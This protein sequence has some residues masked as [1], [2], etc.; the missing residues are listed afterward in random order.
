VPDYYSIAMKSIGQPVD[1]ISDSFCA[2]QQRFTI[3]VEEMK[4]MVV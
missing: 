3:F 4:M 1:T 2:D